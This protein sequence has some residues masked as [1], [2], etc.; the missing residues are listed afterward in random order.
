MRLFFQRNRPE[1]AG[2]RARLR[3]FD[4]ELSSTELFSDFFIVPVN[5]RRVDRDEWVELENYDRGVQMWT[6]FLNEL[7][8]IIVLA[9]I[10]GS[11]VGLSVGL[12]AALAV[13]V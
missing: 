11:V 10:V 8:E 5:L 9:T 13:V 2:L 6:A 4:D 3:H 7:R 12:A 1:A